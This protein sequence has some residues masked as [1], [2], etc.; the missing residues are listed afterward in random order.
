MNLKFKEENI[1]IN[2]E[3]A[4][5]GTI[6]IPEANNKLPAVLI[7]NGS[8][9]ADRDGNMK[10]PAMN[11]NIY[12]ELAHF[13]TGLGFMTLRYDKRGVG[14]SGGEPHTIGMMDLVND[15]KTNIE[16]LKNHPR[17]DAEKIILIGH[18]EGCILSTIVNII[19]PVGGLILL[20]G[21]GTNIWEP[22]QY[23]NRQLL[24]EVKTL[25]GIKGV[26][27]RLALKEEK[28]NKQQESLYAAMINSTGDTIK[29]KGKKMPAKWFREHF[30]Y[31]SDDI[32][33][34][35][36]TAKCPILAVT[37]NKDAQANYRDLE[38]IKALGNSNIQCEIIENMDHMLK[39]FSGQK[40]V[41]NIMKQYK[42][43]MSQSMHPKL[44]A[45]LEEWLNRFNN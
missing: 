40:S 33:T 36:N 37:G 42:N 2:G 7:I 38:K 26:L 41:L 4:L 30:K 13:I 16:F 3:V 44:K 10:K 6:A 28:L 31:S 32:L 8:G 18:S 21:A 11:S 20:S 14:E 35:L 12:K 24:E 22:M 45:L 19:M 1:V 39:E 23:Q 5:S 43:E 34:A 15:I 25:K 9:G 29:F 17:V 27:L